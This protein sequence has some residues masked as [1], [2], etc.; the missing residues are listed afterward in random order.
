ME[1]DAL[2]F[3]HGFENSIKIEADK[4]KIYQVISNLINNA[5]K[6]IDDVE[7]LAGGSQILEEE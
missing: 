4:V 5:I 6:S 1:K 3:I 7:K 2:Q